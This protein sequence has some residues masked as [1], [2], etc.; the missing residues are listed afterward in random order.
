MGKVC[1]VAGLISKQPQAE[2]M[3]EPRKESEVEGKRGYVQF[4]EV[5]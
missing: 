5:D 4:M 1:R 3:E 2:R